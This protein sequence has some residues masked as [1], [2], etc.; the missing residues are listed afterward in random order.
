M[1]VGFARQMVVLLR[2][3]GWDSFCDGLLYDN[4]SYGQTRTLARNKVATFS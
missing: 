3:G 1:C 2:E 4:P